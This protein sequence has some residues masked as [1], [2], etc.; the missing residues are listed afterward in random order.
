MSFTPDE[1][2]RNQKVSD[3]LKDNEK[4]G[5][6][7]MLRKLENTDRILSGSKEFFKSAL[8]NS[9]K[10]DTIFRKQESIIHKEAVS[11]DVKKL[12]IYFRYKVIFSSRDVFEGHLYKQSKSLWRSK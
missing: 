3:V 12:R 1:S 6:Q 7:D 2:T 8:A 11:K 9:Q 4:L 5:L 10:N